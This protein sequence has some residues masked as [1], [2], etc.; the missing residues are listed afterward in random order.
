MTNLSDNS[1]G[2]LTYRLPTT[3]I[4]SHYQLYINVSQLEEYLFQGSVDIDIK[5][6]QLQITFREKVLNV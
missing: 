4:P 3:I 1:V 5:V 6:R 2:E